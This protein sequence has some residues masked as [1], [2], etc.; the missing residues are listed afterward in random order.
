MSGCLALGGV[1]APAGV[2]LCLAC[3]WGA[4]PLM[5]MST[6]FAGAGL[7]FL[8][9]ERHVLRR[10]FWKVGPGLSGGWTGPFMRG[11]PVSCIFTSVVSVEQGSVPGGR[12]QMRVPQKA[13]KKC[14]FWSGG[15]ERTFVSGKLPGRAWLL[16][17]D[18]SEQPA[19]LETLPPWHW[20]EGLRASP[21]DSPADPMDPPPSCAG[22]GLRPSL[23]RIL[24]A[25][26]TSPPQS[27]SRLRP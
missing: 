11:C 12:S 5:E 26:L 15:W 3:E 24:Q 10:V 27:P 1:Q 18:H 14:R 23:G 4:W 8:Y 25:T 20:P 19:G 13:P 6:V 21:G 17:R 16:S 9:S 7:C 22:P 2:A